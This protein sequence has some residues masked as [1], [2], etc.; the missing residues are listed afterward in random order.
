MSFGPDP[1]SGLYLLQ[2]HLG[3]YSSQSGPSETLHEEAQGKNQMRRVQPSE[4]GPQQD[5]DRPFQRELPS[6]HST[7]S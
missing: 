5:E 1:C 3:R 4:Q 2:C 6:A 7:L